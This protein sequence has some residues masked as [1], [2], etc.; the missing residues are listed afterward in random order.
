MSSYIR[1]FINFAISGGATRTE[2]RSLLFR[3]RLQEEGRFSSSLMTF[4]RLSAS[5]IFLRTSTALSPIYRRQSSV[6]TA[7]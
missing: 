6:N 3:G 4:F 5:N 1:D 7:A 2:E